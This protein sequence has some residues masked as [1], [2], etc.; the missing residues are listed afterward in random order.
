MKE[1]LVMGNVIASEWLLGNVVDDIVQGE[2]SN[3]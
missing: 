2:A 3:T 1:L